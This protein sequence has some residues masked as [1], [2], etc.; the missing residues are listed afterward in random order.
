MGEPVKIVHSMPSLQYDGLTLGEFTEQF[1]AAAEGKPL[2]LVAAVVWMLC[3][4][5]AA[6]GIEVGERFAASLRARD[7]GEG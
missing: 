2:D 6:Q 1:K 5:V 4:Q 3:G 7:G